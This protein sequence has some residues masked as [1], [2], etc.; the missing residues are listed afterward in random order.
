MAA[1]KKQNTTTREVK[2]LYT[3]HFPVKNVP[4]EV[5]VEYFKIT[6]I[7]EQD[8]SRYA[9]VIGL[10]RQM[11]NRGHPASATTRKKKG[12]TQADI[13]ALK[14]AEVD[15]TD[16]NHDLEKVDEGLLKK[17]KDI[18]QFRKLF[19]FVV[20]HEFRND[21]ART[22]SHKFVKMEDLKNRNIT[23]REAIDYSIQWIDGN[24]VISIEPTRREMIPLNE[25][26]EGQTARAIPY[27]SKLEVVEATDRKFNEEDIGSLNG[28][29]YWMYKHAIDIP[30]NSKLVMVRTDDGNEIPYPIHALFQ[31]HSDAKI[32]KSERKK[33]K[34]PPYKRLQ[35][36]QELVNQY[37]DKI[38]FGNK[39]LRVRR[40]GSSAKDLNLSTGS[41]G[42]QQDRQ[43][44]FGEGHTNNY[45]LYGLRDHGPISGPKDVHVH[46]ICYEEDKK[47]G[48]DLLE[49][50]EREFEDMNL[51]KLHT[52]V[53]DHLMTPNKYPDAFEDKADIYF[54]EIHGQKDRLDMP[55]IL[56]PDTNSNMLSQIYF[57]HRGYLLPRQIGLQSF[58]ASTARDVTGSDE[59][60]KEEAGNAV[61]IHTALQLYT[62][63]DMQPPWKLEK[64]ADTN[65]TTGSDSTCFVGFDTSRYHEEKKGASAYSAVVDSDGDIVYLGT[66][67]FSGEKMTVKDIRKVCRNLIRQTYK[68]KGD[69][70]KRLVIYRDGS[71]IHN[72][73]ENWREAILESGEGSRSIK[74]MIENGE[75]YPDEMLMDLV[76][77]NKSPSTRVFKKKGDKTY[78]P[79]PGTYVLKDDNT[80]WLSATDSSRGTTV[81]PLEFQYK[82]RFS[83]GNSEH[84]KESVV[85]IM[86][87][88]QTQTVLNWAS[89]YSNTKFALPQVLTQ[90]IAKHAAKGQAPRNVLMI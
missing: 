48:E 35:K 30:D 7:N 45:E 16:L 47:L 6:D 66:D 21:W 61:A 77:V 4:E 19:E 67:S 24:P 9:Q 54:N 40:S 60:R 73:S 57:S 88:Y 83:L 20:G 80:G 10:A 22:G 39:T 32:D 79:D 62:K 71:D 84:E 49:Q 36:C 50:L 17:D 42:S 33:S 70:F 89:I 44:K 41:V 27:W 56:M 59:F 43:L 85:Q 29:E 3:N 25:P 23:S 75:S 82:E 15:D 37:F 46:L 68:K 51:G 65:S 69:D 8:G 52:H 78:N 28:K 31:E 2:N 76:Y 87:E 53:D 14:P 12:K 34:L 26:E 86:D 63:P 58:K 5:E 13:V 18:G 55:L 90:E 72:E 81:R 11:N 64:A 1:S 38:N 74:E